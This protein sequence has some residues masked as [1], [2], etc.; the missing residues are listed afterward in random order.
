MFS[1]STNIR[2]DNPVKGDSFMFANYQYF[3]HNR[4]QQGF[5]YEGSNLRLGGIAIR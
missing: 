2:M 3:A 4:N 5:A 1:V